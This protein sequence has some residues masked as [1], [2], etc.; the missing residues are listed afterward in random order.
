MNL[1]RGIGQ[2]VL[3]ENEED[4]INAASEQAKVDVK[5]EFILMEV[6]RA[7][8][9]T[10]NQEDLV[11][12]ISQIAIN[13]ET[14]PDRVVKTIKKNNG[15]DSLRHSILLGKA[16]DVLVQHANVAYEDHAE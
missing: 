7:E 10:V 13:T 1:E 14:T 16:L 12:R 6:V 15:I 2:D 4:I 9:L 8:K 3:V 5:D 11:R